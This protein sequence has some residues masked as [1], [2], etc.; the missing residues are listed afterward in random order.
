MFRAGFLKT[1]ALQ[2]ERYLLKTGISL[3][4]GD[5]TTGN[6]TLTIDPTLS[7]LPSPLVPAPTGSWPKTNLPVLNK[8]ILTGLTFT[9]APP[10][11]VFK[12]AFPWPGGPDDCEGQRRLRGGGPRD[13]RRTHPRHSATRRRVLHNGLRL[14]SGNTDESARGVGLPFLVPKPVIRKIFHFPS[15]ILKRLPWHMEVDPSTTNT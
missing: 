12:G 6:F 10:T 13:V 3:L 15:R 14:R 7:A 9:F 8:P 1:L 4:T 11:G 2:G 5:A